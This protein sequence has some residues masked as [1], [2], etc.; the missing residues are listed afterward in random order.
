MSDYIR[1]NVLG[2]VAIFIA[3][4]GT[5]WAAGKIGGG[6]IKNNAIQSKHLL[7]E[8]IKPTDIAPNAIYSWHIKDGEVKGEDVLNGS[9]G[10]D[11]IADSSLGGEHIANNS[12]SARDLATIVVR[13][14][15]KEVKSTSQGGEQF[16]TVE[17][18]CAPGEQALGGGA[19][20]DFA[21]DRWY[22]TQSGPDDVAIEDT[23]F[24]RG[25]DELI[26]DGTG[27]L[28]DGAGFTGW[29]AT[30]G[31]GELS[32]RDELTVYAICLQQ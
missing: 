31:I 13:S 24:G 20:K 16:Y 27:P 23:V 28:A 15:S 12:L 11:D 3:L 22:L 29:K 19:R 18:H 32:G 2:L 26:G 9:L 4:S 5:A 10:G 30:W 17:S 14:Q 1:S 8:T 25:G 21:D 7:K 6:A